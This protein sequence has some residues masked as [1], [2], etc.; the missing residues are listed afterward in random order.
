MAPTLP[1]SSGSDI[2]ADSLTVLPPS[3]TR[4]QNRRLM[5]LNRSEYLN[6]STVQERLFPYLYKSLILR[7]ATPV[8][9]LDEVNTSKS[10]SLT[11]VLLDAQTHMAKLQAKRDR[12]DDERALD[13]DKLM[14]EQAVVEM[15]PKEV[16]AD[17]EKSRLLLEKMI[18]E[19]FLEGGDDEFD[20]GSVDQDEKWD[21]LETEEEEIRAKYFEEES[22]DVEGEDGEEKVLSG[23]TGVQDF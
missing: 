17:R 5:Y 1:S 11:H 12:T 2:I 3:K 21:D 14:M 15:T 20:Y 6:T 16:L 8:E 23:E 19:K 4:I 10:R 7:H 18:R 13:E 22:T 9:K